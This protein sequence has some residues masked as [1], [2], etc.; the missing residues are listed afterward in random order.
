MQRYIL[1]N[2]LVIR[3][4]YIGDSINAGT[5]PSV[6]AGKYIAIDCEIVGVGPTPDIDSA[7][8]RVS[9]VNYHGQQLYGSFVLPKETATDYHTAVSGITPHLLRSARPSAGIRSRVG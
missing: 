7:L 5:S 3:H 1:K 4:K 2:Y 9:V 8:A 6:E